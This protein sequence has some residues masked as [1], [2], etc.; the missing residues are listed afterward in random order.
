M[1]RRRGTRARAERAA[2]GSPTLLVAFLVVCKTGRRRRSNSLRC[3]EPPE[4]EE[5]EWVDWVDWSG[6][7]G[8]VTQ[9]EVGMFCLV[10]GWRDIVGG[11][12]TADVSGAP[13]HVW[14]FGESTPP[15]GLSAEWSRNIHRVD[16]SAVEL[17]RKLLHRII[18]IHKTRTSLGGVTRLPLTQAG[19]SVPVSRALGLGPGSR[20]KRKT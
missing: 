19:L 3:T 2:N 4:G 1:S 6:V 13:G 12:D 5:E 15:G 17:G 8:R 20:S 16:A 7:C 10:G 14:G 9:V 11:W 18:I